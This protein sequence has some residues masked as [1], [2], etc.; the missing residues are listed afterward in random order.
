[1]LIDNNL[2]H[3]ISEVLGEIKSTLGDSGQ[4]DIHGSAGDILKERSGRYRDVDIKWSSE[5]IKYGLLKGMKYSTSFNVNDKKYNINVVGRLTDLG[6]EEAEV[7]FDLDEY[8]GK[9]NVIRRTGT[10]D[11]FKVM[12]TV[13]NSL[14][15]L[16]NDRKEIQSVW[17]SSH[18][19][20]KNPLFKRLSK[21]VPAGLDFECSYSSKI[22][23][24]RERITF[25]RISSKKR[26]RRDV[27]IQVVVRPED[28]KS[29]YLKIISILD[30]KFEYKGYYKCGFHPYIY[31]KKYTKT[32]IES[33]NLDKKVQERIYQM[34][35]SEEDSHIAIMNILCRELKLKWSKSDL[36]RGY[37][38]FKGERI[39]LEDATK[40]I[41]P[42]CIALK[43]RRNRIEA[44]IKPGFILDI[45]IKDNY[46][47]YPNYIN[48][49]SKELVAE[50]YNSRF[51]ELLMYEEYY[52]MFKWLQ[53]F[54]EM[55]F[56][57]S[58]Y[59]KNYFNR[60]QYSYLRNCYEMTFKKID[61]RTM[62]NQSAMDHVIKVYGECVKLKIFKNY[63]RKN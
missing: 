17:W 47:K 57:M 12:S 23:G 34:L 54:L 44:E 43:D 32:G 6:V 35:E 60:R 38:E 52:K 63:G 30:K 50:Q 25:N 42:D 41:N 4:V 5:E 53:R 1:M 37:T 55:I 61:Y 27:D 18:D 48:C 33:L 20:K 45:Q 3:I 28:I 51:E 29:T 59:R 8:K 24:G 7:T 11:S 31:S 16:G 14:I 10:G 21:M 26:D 46:C 2:R 13:L 56:V 15:K 62:N 9:K 49:F 40:V 58:I 19:S 36:S 39:D 22:V